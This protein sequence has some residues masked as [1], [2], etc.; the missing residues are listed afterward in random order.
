M[1]S[2]LQNRTFRGGEPTWANACVGDNGSPGII[3]YAEGFADA[4]T[5][6]LDQVLGD[7]LRHSTDT[8]IYPI[9][10]NMRHAAELYL[11]AAIQSLHSLDG[12]SYRL[13]PFD[14]DGSHDIGRIWA[15]FRDQ[16]PSV[17]WRYRRAVDEL[18]SDISDIAAV[19]PNGQVFRYPFG[20]E[21][22]KHL[23]EV[24]IINCRV[25]REQFSEIRRKLS[26]LGRLSVDLLYEYS[27]GTYTARLSR[28]D[29]LCIAH[30]LPPR[31]EW[32]TVAFDEAKT[33]VKRLFDI[34][35][36]EFSR[37]VGR[38]KGN[39]EM[40]SLIDAPIPLDHCGPEQLFA[41][42][43]AW[44]KLNDREEVLEW[45]FRE[46]HEIREVSE[47]VAQEMFSNLERRMRVRA[48]TWDIVARN[49]SLEAIGE[50][51]ALFNFYRIPHWYGEE[52]EKERLALTRDLTSKREA[53]GSYYQDSV[54]NF[55]EKFT[56]LPE[57]LN[58]LNFFGHNNLLDLLIDRYKLS[59]HIERLL[60]DS[61]RRSECR[62][63]TIQEYLRVRA[64]GGRGDRQPA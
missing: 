10:F 43:D 37:A 5:V 6:L 14:L 8:F 44:F 9:C 19:D 25:L 48:E 40:A 28:L 53:G 27:L 56:V 60:E 41:F 64:N 62:S 2:R 36:R 18:E 51:D 21:N 7:H 45:L 61:K 32:G 29:L 31:A 34:S 26:E 33:E 54:L 46:P 35:S 16:A 3:E 20:R 58:S 50:L 47:D 38:V 30:M 1:D 59:D 12:R 52:Y 24:A 22:N 39:R 55:M 57:V 23:E 42:F 4:A 63:T 49:L 13:P 15:H 11:K 17:D